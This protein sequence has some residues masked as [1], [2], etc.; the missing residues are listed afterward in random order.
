MPHYFRPFLR[1]HERTSD[2][3]I[4]LSFSRSSVRVKMVYSVYKKQR[5]LYLHSQVYRPPTIKQMLDKE[6]LK[7]SRVGIHKFLKIYFATRSISR[8][9]GSGRPSKVTGEIKQLVEQQ[10]RIDDETT[11]YQLHRMLTDR[12][13]SILLRTILRCRT[14]LGWTSRGSAYCQLIQEANKQKRFQW[15]Q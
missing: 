7:C 10:M 4:V 2:H 6:K 12:G 11:A 1:T 9:A 8:R 5:I 13:Y 15:V 14:M 3:M